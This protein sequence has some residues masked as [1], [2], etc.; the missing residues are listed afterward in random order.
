[1][2]NPFKSWFQSFVS[3][4]TRARLRRAL[5]HLVTECRFLKLVAGRF[6][7]SL[8]VSVT[9]ILFSAWILKQWYPIIPGEEA[10]DWDRALYSV[11]MMVAFGP[12]LNFPSHAP[13]FVKAILLGLPLLGL[14]VIID[15]VVRFAG[16]MFERRLQLKEW[17]ILLASTYRQH[18]IICGLGHVGYRTAQ[19]LLDA[20]IDCVG[21]EIADNP[22]AGE[23]AK[24]GM[25]VLKGDCRARE[26]LLQAGVEKARAIL[27]VTDNDV[28]N[29]ESAL[30]AREVAPGIRTV[31]RL[32][33][34]SLAK[35][36]EKLVEIDAAFSTSELAAPIFAAAVTSQKVLH[37]FVTQGITLNTVEMTVPNQSPLIH[38]TLDEIQQR[39]EL[40]FLCLRR[41]EH[42]DWNPR[43]ERQLQAGDIL[44]IVGTAEVLAAF[45]ALNSGTRFTETR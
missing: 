15:A 22:F 24:R 35:K 19:R 31:I 29:I 26:Q 28:V 2:I 14:F 17:Q 3:T 23:L 38:Q 25:P 13:W 21:I 1:M 16:L 36:I 34:Q 8:G 44:I 43:T 45:E 42:I 18:V 41:G 40:T 32:F 7:W 20:H 39:L 37:S 27:V 11:V 10:L 5:S 12:A 33:D 9:V 30:S 6:Q 4:A